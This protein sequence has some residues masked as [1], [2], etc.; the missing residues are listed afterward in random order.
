MFQTNLSW[1][2]IKGRKAYRFLI[3]N[4]RL[5]HR[6]SIINNHASPA[7]FKSERLS[8]DP[9]SCAWPKSWPDLDQPNPAQP[10][11]DP[12]LSRINLSLVFN[13]LHQVSAS[14]VEFW[15]VPYVFQPVQLNFG[16]SRPSF[17]WFVVFLHQFSLVRPSLRYFEIGPSS[18]G[19]VCW[20][21]F[22]IS[23]S[24]VSIMNTR[25]EVSSSLTALNSPMTSI[26]FKGK[27]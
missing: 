18:F 10:A 7:Q 2:N 26:K 15:L 22:R 8:L 1:I 17:S 16:P 14:S 4:I 6:Y 24:I 20:L 27:N 13:R 11:F 12:N 23:Y 25:L 5:A 21:N 3:D 19:H 9:F